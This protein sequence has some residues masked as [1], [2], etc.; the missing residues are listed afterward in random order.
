MRLID[1][2]LINVLEEFWDAE[3]TRLADFLEKIVPCTDEQTFVLTKNFTLA[4][5]LETSFGKW[6][7]QLGNGFFTD[8][9][10]LL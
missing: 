7:D 2:C 4:H 10:Y 8:S 3:D 9:E 5:E 6:P 1:I